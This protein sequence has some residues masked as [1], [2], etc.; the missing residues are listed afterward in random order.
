[1]T[2]GAGSVIGIVIGTATFAIVNQGIFFSG[3][4]PNVGSVIIGV[5]LLAAVL[6]NDGFRA[7]ALKYSTRK[8]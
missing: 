8:G 7:I 3:L 5:M 2:G 1:L 4:D 6:S